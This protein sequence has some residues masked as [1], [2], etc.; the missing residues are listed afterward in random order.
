[1]TPYL[2][3]T[4]APV[5]GPITL[6]EAKSFC[7]I[8]HSLKDTDISAFIQTAAADVENYT[9]YA[10]GEQTWVYRSG[11]WP[12]CG[13]IVELERSPLLAVAS[14]KYYPAGGGAQATVSSADYYVATGKRPGFV[15]FADTYSFPALA[16]RHDAVEITFT[17]GWSDV[18]AIDPV[19]LHAVKLTVRELLDRPDTIITG[20]IISEVPRLR[21]LLDSRRV[22]GVVAP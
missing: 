19:L 6:A 11:Q 9:G 13:R 14:V 15:Q 7:D 5:S 8:Q 17:A 18:T 3:R 21:N 16:V 10:L 20:T 12:A 4:V 2:T 1:L 22:R